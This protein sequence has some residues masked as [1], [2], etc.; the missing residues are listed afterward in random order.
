MNQETLQK[1]KAGRIDSPSGG[2]EVRA[3]E[4]QTAA[5]ELAAEKKKMRIPRGKGYFS[6]LK[7]A[8]TPSEQ[9]KKIVEAV[10]ALPVNNKL[11]GILTSCG[12]PGCIAHVIDKFG[13]ILTHFNREEEMGEALR[14]GY[15]ILLSHPDC[16]SVEVY[17]FTFCVV[18]KGGNVEIID[19]QGS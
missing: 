19:R 5:S 17:T 16:I 4:Q 14:A 6:A 3:L 9:D 18:Y 12:L 10:Q 1:L 11:E 13:D 7:L 2:G 8:D 15:H